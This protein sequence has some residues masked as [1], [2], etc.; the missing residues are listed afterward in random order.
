MYE[1]KVKREARKVYR[2]LGT[3]EKTAKEMQKRGYP[4]ISRIT[5]QRWAKEQDWDSWCL[6]MD[7]KESDFDSV[8]LDYDK[9]ILLDLEEDREM[10]RGTLKED[11]DNSQLWFA[12][13]GNVS[14]ILKIIEKKKVDRAAIIDEVIRE[15][16]NDP[17]AG[18]VLLA[19]KTH[20][21]KNLEKRK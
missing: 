14:T 12:Y 3:P 13:Q 7:K 15:F 10:L 4:S 1:P 5:I 19:R 16:I 9:E 20:I 18:K 21:L 2:E 6:K 8:V 11:V 17:V